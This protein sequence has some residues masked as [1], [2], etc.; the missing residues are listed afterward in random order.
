[1][2]SCC[3]QV[4]RLTEHLEINDQKILCILF[5]RGG[6][7]LTLV[8]TNN[9]LFSN[10]KLRSF[11]LRV[12]LLLTSVSEFSM[13]CPS[14]AIW[15]RITVTYNQCIFSVCI[16]GVSTLKSK[17]QSWST[18]LFFLILQLI[19]PLQILNQR[20]FFLKFLLTFRSY[21]IVI[22]LKWKFNS[23]IAWNSPSFYLVVLG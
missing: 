2:F 20:K 13:D 12:N 14:I 1:M 8:L 5:V 23:N 9:F 22:S 16:S 6:K 3:T 15:S 11:L 19:L 7:R 18:L 10:C 4:R 21:S 17:T